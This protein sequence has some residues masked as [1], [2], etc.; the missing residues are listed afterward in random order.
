MVSPSERA[1][2]PPPETGGYP[3]PWPLRR[4]PF[5][6][7]AAQAAAIHDRYHKSLFDHSNLHLGSLNQ[8]SD[9]MGILIVHR[10]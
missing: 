1:R 5:R 10:P 6:A 8:K 9:P 2:R 4:W 3:L 7:N